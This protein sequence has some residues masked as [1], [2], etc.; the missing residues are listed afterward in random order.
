MANILV[1]VA[2]PDDELLGVAGT[3]RRSVDSGD[4]AKC[5]ILAEGMTSRTTK[6]EDTD[7]AVLNSLHN[8]TLES[9]KHIGYN[10]VFFADFPD[11]RMDGCELLDVVKVV[12][13]HIE[14]FKPD[15]I[16]THHFGDLNVDHQVVNQAVLTASR[17]IGKDCV[18]EIYTFETPSSTEW[19]YRYATDVFRP[20]VFVDIESTI[21]AKI[22]A[23]ACYESELRDYPHPRSL[24]AL[25]IIAKRWGT[26]VGMNYCEA[27]ELIRK[28]EF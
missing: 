6:R 4:E 25:R 7:R 12:E 2:H 22:N 11:N 24:E 13:K 19:Q 14:A 8:D 26:V 16:Y 23:M 28:I 17:P 1:I 5:L 27:F 21:D 18:K 9:A 15:V 10:E 3:I 20:N